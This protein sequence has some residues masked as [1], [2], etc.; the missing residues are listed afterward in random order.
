MARASPRKGD[1]WHWETRHRNNTIGK[2]LFKEKPPGGVVLSGL[3]SPLCS[4]SAT[5]K[6]RQRS[7]RASP[8]DAQ[9]YARPSRGRELPGSGD[10]APG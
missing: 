3:L 10:Q 9:S 6:P 7:D 5:K 8:F 4:R 2:G 1:T